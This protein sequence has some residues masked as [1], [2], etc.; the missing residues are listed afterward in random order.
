M[1]Q[2]VQLQ[3]AESC[4]KYII[5]Y[6]TNNDPNNNDN[7]DNFISIHLTKSINRKT[8]RHS[9][10]G[11]KQLAIGLGSVNED[12]LTELHAQVQVPWAGRRRDL[13]QQ[14]AH[15]VVRL[16]VVH[17]VGQDSDG[18]VRGVLEE[19]RLGLQERHV[20]QVLL[21]ERRTEEAA[22]PRPFQ[23]GRLLPRASTSFC[24]LRCFYPHKQHNGMQSH[25]PE[26]VMDGCNGWTPLL[27]GRH[28]AAP[29]GSF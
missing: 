16:V 20:P 29:E 18:V 26:N 25:E 4:K 6:H 10:V 19:V 13:G 22:E 2:I 5:S 1:H 3:H 23:R 11:K 17:R 15:G 14:E 28:Q 21:R 27:Y 8:V 7:C 24:C 9:G 12:M